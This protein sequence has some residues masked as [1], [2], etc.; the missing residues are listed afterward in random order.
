MSARDDLEQAAEQARSRVREAREALA[1]SRSALGGGPARTAKEA[2]RQLLSLRRSVTDDVLSLRERLSG[3]DAGAT[4]ALRITA[5]STSG[6]I[7]GVVGAGLLSRNAITKRSERRSMQQQ[8]VALARALAEQAV[9]AVDRDSAPTAPRS[10]RRSRGG[11]RRA[12][13]LALAGATATGVMVAQLRRNA[14]IDE[15]DL[16]LPVEPSG[17]A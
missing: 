1:S 6:A 8:A 12:A 10:G 9:N 13:L 15:D 3:K 2:E 11:R 7:A 17:P 16:W 4:R 5:L 14:T